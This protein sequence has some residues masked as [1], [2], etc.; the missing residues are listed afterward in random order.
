MILSYKQFLIQEAV[1]MSSG[2]QAAGGM[3]VAK[4]SVDDAYAYINKIFEDCFKKP[5]DDY[6]PNFKKNYLFGQNLADKGMTVRKDMPVIDEK[7]VKVLQRR[8]KD[9]D[10]D[11]RA[12][13]AKTDKNSPEAFPTGLTG[14]D[15]AKWLKDGL[16]KY[17]GAGNKTD[18]V[19][20]CAMV[21]VEAGK[22]VPIQKQIY[23]DKCFNENQIK[24]GLDS[25]IKF[26]KNTALII[27]SDDHIIDGHHRWMEACIIDPKMKLKALQ[28]DLPIATL[29]PLCL[30]YGDAVGNKRN[31]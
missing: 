25:S 19:V 12:P 5:V 22:L 15:A 8:L 28:I 31:Q 10:L 18:D 26:L 24:N 13:Y 20:K 7:D 14:E 4:T 23:F 27:S 21:E 1:D 6:L 29:L 17:D 3:E 16:P 9:G 2:G 30:A 11:V